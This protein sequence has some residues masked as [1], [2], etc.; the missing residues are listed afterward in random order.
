[1]KEGR[2]LGVSLIAATQTISGLGNS[3]IV[4][5]FMQAS[6]KFFFKPSD[7]EL[8]KVATLLNKIDSRYSALEWARTLSQLKIGECVFFSGSNAQGKV[9]KITSLEERLNNA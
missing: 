2:K 1:L 6:T 4:D 7:T 3:G 9:I 8:N 5:E